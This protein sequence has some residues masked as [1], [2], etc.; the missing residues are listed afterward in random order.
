MTKPKVLLL[1]EIEYAHDAWNALSDIATLITPQSTTRPAFLQE[2]TSG[3]LDGVHTIF[4]T[5]DS[6]SLTGP[7]DAELIAA[8]PSSLRFC[9]HNGAGYDAIDVA[10]C[11]ARTPP[12][13]VSNCP[14][15]VDDAT[16]DAALFL[17]LGALR[18]FN[19][20]MLALR[21]GKWRGEPAPPLGHDPRGKVLGILGMGGIG[22]N[23]KRKCDAL[24]MRTIYH[25]RKPLGAE[26]AAGAE[27]VEF[28][29]LLA[30]A[31][32]VSLNLPLNPHTRH[33]I[34]HA[35][36]AK[37]KPGVVIVNTAR[38]GVLD[39]EALVQALDS[40]HVRSCGLDV[41]DDE[42]N[43]HSGLIRNENVMLLP[44]MGTYTLETMAAMEERVVVN[45]REA[46]T[47]GRLVDLVVE[48]RGLV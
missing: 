1:G 16:A 8:L 42:P 15:A 27:Y 35:Q 17:L 7:W 26:E 41:Y 11:S 46:V 47:K 28:D 31:D 24:G 37:M 19:S 3:Q 33:I 12:L 30:R 13:L 18:G 36:L 25:N 45:V 14:K 38:G 39:E 23:L 22:R 4:R 44:H 34:S 10:A 43:V 29:E 6:G 48:Q 9:C 20:S 32:V 2:C 21:E 40:G 5:F